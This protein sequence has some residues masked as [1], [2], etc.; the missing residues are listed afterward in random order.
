MLF[1][2]GLIIGVNIGFIL[3]ALMVAAGKDDRNE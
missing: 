3:M 2:A 1:V